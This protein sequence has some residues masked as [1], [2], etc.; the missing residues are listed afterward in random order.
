MSSPLV[1]QTCF[2]LIVINDSLLIAILD[3]VIQGSTAT[4]NQSAD[5]SAFLTTCRNTNTRTDC[6]RSSDSQ[7]GF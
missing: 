7:S 2:S 3:Q 5:R 1:L 6:R 4:A